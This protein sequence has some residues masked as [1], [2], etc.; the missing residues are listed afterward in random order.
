MRYPSAEA[1]ARDVAAA[2]D[3][4]APFPPTLPPVGDAAARTASGVYVA[5]PA[6]EG[7]YLCGTP[8]RAD[9]VVGYP[10]GTRLQVIDKDVEAEG[11][12]W[13]LVCD[14]DGRAGFVEAEKLS[15]VPGPV[16]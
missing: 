14:E 10:N 9:R 8:S 5:N 13:T 15:T 6:G 11:V 1:F 12:I 3:E 2:L 7:A 4:A 16:R